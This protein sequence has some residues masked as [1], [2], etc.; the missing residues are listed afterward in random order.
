MGAD[1][2]LRHVVHKRVH[3]ERHQPKARKRK[4]ATIKKL[5][6]KAYFKNEDEFSM[7]MTQYSTNKD[8]KTMK[9]THLTQ[10]FDL[11]RVLTLFTVWLGPGVAKA[12]F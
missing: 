12:S 7:T 8:W 1:G 2:G 6:R 9:K 3:L 11:P 10:V 5:H 4:E